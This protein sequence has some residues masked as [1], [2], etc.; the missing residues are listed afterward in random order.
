MSPLRQQMIAVSLAG[1][2]CGAA[3]ATAIL[4][5]VQAAVFHSSCSLGPSVGFE[6]SSSPSLPMS[7]PEPPT[8]PT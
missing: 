2:L 3:I 7:P 1:G 5:I 4:L 8:S 6:S